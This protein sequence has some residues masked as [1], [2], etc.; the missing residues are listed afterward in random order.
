MKVTCL[1]A[2]KTFKTNQY[3]I[4]YSRNSSTLYRTQHF[5]TLFQ[6]IQPQLLPILS[7][8]N[9]VSDLPS[10]FSLSISFWS[11]PGS[12]VGIA[13]DYGLDGPGIESQWMRDFP[14]VQ[15][16]PGAHPA[17]CTMGIESFPGVKCGQGVLLTTHPLLAPRS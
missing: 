5:V 13:T 7:Q 2:A 12:S 16:D 8:M 11:G 9:P 15:T 17:S 1:P 14:P 3:V 10:I 6:R 4:T